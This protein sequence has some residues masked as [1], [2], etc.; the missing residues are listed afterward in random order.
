ML[1]KLV[2]VGRTAMKE[3]ADPRLCRKEKASR[4]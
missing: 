4:A 3:D 2:K 1:V